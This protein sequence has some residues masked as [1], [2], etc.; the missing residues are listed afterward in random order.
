MC[1]GLH[2][3]TPRLWMLAQT[4]SQLE[5]VHFLEAAISDLTAHEVGHT[6]GLRH[7][8]QGSTAYS[9]E[10]LQDPAFV[11][12]HGLTAS[13]MDYLPVNS[14]SSEGRKQIVKDHFQGKDPGHAPHWNTVVGVYDKMAIKYGY[15]EIEDEHCCG[16][17][18]KLDAIAQDFH[19][20]KLAFGTDYDA[21]Y[22]GGVSPYV[23]VFDLG[24]EPL[25]YRKDQLVLVKETQGAIFERA[26][27]KKES[28]TRLGRVQYSLL[29]H[30]FW[31]ADAMA[32]YVGGLT[33][34]RRHA[35]ADCATHNPS[36]CMLHE[37]GQETPIQAVSASLQDDAVTT[38]RDTL[39]VAPSGDG[40][41]SS[42]FASTKLQNWMVTRG[43]EFLHVV[44]V[45][46]G[47][48]EAQVRA[49]ALWSVMHPSRLRR[50]WSSSSPAGGDSAGRVGNHFKALSRGIFG[51]DSQ[52]EGKKVTHDPAQWNIQLEYASLLSDTAKC[53]G[54]CDEEEHQVAVSA[55]GEVLRL[56]NLLEKM[57]ALK[58]TEVSNDASAQDW[59]HIAFLKS[60]IAIFN[61][62]LMQPVGSM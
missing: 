3:Y 44:P 61:A 12:E 4:P 45:D 48:W 23:A 27:L 59:R 28:F 26:V 57:L 18:P 56:Q 7:N 47:A 36:A 55:L 21:W 42:V 40:E 5:V 60:T 38:I 15:I 16:L 46:L 30:A 49:G 19:D 54:Y 50:L 43:F 34:S 20:K 6:L 11:R 1:R 62:T 14:L 58:L 29:T 33:I 9:I 35:I 17:H 10:Q 22:L 52:S 41:G 37:G 39:I 53:F 13:V 8:F 51:A 24:S 2:D 32:Q 25:S 31:T